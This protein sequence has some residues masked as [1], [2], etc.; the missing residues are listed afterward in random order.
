M[1][2]LSEPVIDQQD[3]RHVLE[4][5]DSGWISTTG[6]YVSKLESLIAEIVG[7]KRGVAVANGTSGL[8]MALKAIGVGPGDKVLVPTITFVASV[9][10]I[11]HTG[12]E[13]VFLDCDDHLNLNIEE[14][15]RFLGEYRDDVKAIMPVHLF[16]NPCDMET[17]NNLAKEDGMFVVEDAC[18]A[19]GS[20]S[21]DGMCGHAG[22]IGIFSFSFNKLITSGNGGMVVTDNEE[23]ADKIKYWITQSKDDPVNY[24]HNEIGYNLGLTNI[25]AALGYGQAEKLQ[26]SIYRKQRIMKTYEEHLCKWDLFSCPDHAVSS[27]S[28]FVGLCVENARS[29]KILTEELFK[30]GIQT[31]PLF[32]PNHLQKPFEDFERFGTLSIAEYYKDRVINL[33][34][35][36]NL[37]DKEIKMICDTVNEILERTI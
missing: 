4:A 17:I 23:I 35:S 32:T 29:K 24:I 6:P 15:A 13:P 27:N 26:T 20:E 10:A 5:L 1:I 14:F 30:A 12:A 9:N 22:D 28:W 34:C 25:H 36:I 3:K 37:T 11:L 33:P 2:P 16:G 21:N 19:L 7:A 8:F 18:Q 31:R